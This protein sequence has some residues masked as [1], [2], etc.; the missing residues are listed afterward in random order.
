MGVQ[1]RIARRRIDADL[2]LLNRPGYR[3]TD[4]WLRAVRDALG[5]SEFELA[6][7]MGI[8]QQRVNQI[9]RA[10]VDRSIQLSTFGRA[11]EA[12]GCELVYYLAP[13]E[14]LEDMVSRQAFLKAAGQVG[15]DPDD[16][17]DD[18]RAIRKAEEADALAYSWVDRRG[19]WR[20]DAARGRPPQ[21]NAAPVPP[22]PSLGP[23]CGLP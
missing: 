6:A 15:Y 22:A 1:G 9:Q 19:L 10:E 16:P 5:M 11:A 7:R 21:A 17:D 3:P 12:L 14:P 4:G 18:D 2:S 8:T 13:K 23:S 20:P